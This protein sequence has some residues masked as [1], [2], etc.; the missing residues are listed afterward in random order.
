MKVCIM[1]V[2]ALALALAGCGGVSGETASATGGPVV[3]V[4]IDP[5]AS[6]E[7]TCAEGASGA[8]YGQEHDV[9]IECNGNEGGAHVVCG[10]PSTISWANGPGNQ[11]TVTC[12]GEVKP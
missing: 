6:Y 5:P 11:I 9:T 4:A 12:T 10:Q 2:L 1:A 8:T 7:S 3:D